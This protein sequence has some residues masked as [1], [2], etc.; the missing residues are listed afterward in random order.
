[1]LLRLTFHDLTF[2]MPV[3]NCIGAMPTG[4]QCTSAMPKDVTFSI[5]ASVQV[6]CCQLRVDRLSQLAMLSQKPSTC[7]YIDMDASVYANVY[8][9]YMPVYICYICQCIYA[10]VYMVT[11]SQMLVLSWLLQVRADYWQK[12]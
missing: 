1:M 10:S 2:H 8:M 11:L 7:I 12:G 4:Q 3:S 6:L 9:L 5:Q